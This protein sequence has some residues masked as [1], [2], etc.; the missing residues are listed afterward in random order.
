[1]WAF[2]TARAFAPMWR[3]A[4]EVLAPGL[5]LDDRRVQEHV[6]SE[7]RTE[8]ETARRHPTILSRHPLDLSVDTPDPS[9][10]LEHQETAEQDA[11]RAD[12]FR[13]LAA[14]EYGEA[15]QRFVDRLLEQDFRH[16]R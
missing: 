6:R 3:L 12:A 5:L 14:A 15:G 4:H 8:W 10:V 7:R 11:S 16:A 9:V 2:M 1:M 13:R